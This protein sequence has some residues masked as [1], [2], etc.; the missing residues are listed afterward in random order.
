VVLMLRPLR[1]VNPVPVR[2]RQLLEHA[3]RALGLRCVRV[4]GLPAGDI[5]EETRTDA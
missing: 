1:S 3:L 5:S 2:V 4:N